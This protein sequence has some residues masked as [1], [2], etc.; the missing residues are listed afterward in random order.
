MKTES[1]A[2]EQSDLVGNGQTSNLGREAIAA[3]SAAIVILKP[4]RCSQPLHG[5]RNGGHQ[6][7]LPR[8]L[9]ALLPAKC[10]STAHGSPQ[11]RRFPTR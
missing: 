4:K 2:R 3:V 9:S 7:S 11:D 8:G 5:A 10:L 1:L 6:L